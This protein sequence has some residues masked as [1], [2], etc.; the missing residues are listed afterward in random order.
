[1][2]IDPENTKTEEVTEEAGQTAEPDTE[3]TED[4]SGAEAQTEAEE[5]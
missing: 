3:Q 1:M 2:A 5:T 4:T